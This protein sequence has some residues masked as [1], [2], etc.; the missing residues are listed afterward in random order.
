MEGFSL[1]F[2]SSCKRKSRRLANRWILIHG[3]IT[4][5]CK[6]PGVSLSSSVLPV[7]LLRGRECSGYHQRWRRLPPSW[8]W[9]RQLPPIAAQLGPSY[10]PPTFPPSTH[11]RNAAGSCSTSQHS[12]PSFVDLL[13][14]SKG[15]V[16]LGG[17]LEFI[18]HHD[19]LEIFFLYYGKYF[20]TRLKP[21]NGITKVYMTPK[22]GRKTFKLNLLATLFPSDLPYHPRCRDLPTVLGI[23]CSC[24]TIGKSLFWCS[25][26]AFIANFLYSIWSLPEEV[27]RDLIL[28]NTFYFTFNPGDSLAT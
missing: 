20:F 23:L 4:G 12:V 16:L 10:C 3:S 11:S 5:S 7:T 8:L 18:L 24:Y 28:L 19:Y 2:S 25:M 17:N 9:P 15:D 27:Q 6:F 22:W 14:R 26:L 21:G 13:H 1:L